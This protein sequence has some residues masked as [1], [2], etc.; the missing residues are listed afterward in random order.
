M[1]NSFELCKNHSRNIKLQPL[2]PSMRLEALS[3]RF[4]DIHSAS[5]AIYVGIVVIIYFF[6]SAIVRPNRM[7]S[8]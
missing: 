5:S 6:R 8:K 2:P 3:F 1:N 4:L 7:M